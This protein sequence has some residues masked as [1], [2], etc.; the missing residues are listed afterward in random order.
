MP[1][2]RLASTDGL[3]DLSDRRPLLDQHLQFGSIQTPARGVLPLI[4]S[5]KSMLIHPI[6]DGRF[7][8]VKPPADLRKR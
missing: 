6:G 7:V 8:T 3:G 1:D 5:L 4:D 2:R